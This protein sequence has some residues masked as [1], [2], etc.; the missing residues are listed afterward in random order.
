MISRSVVGKFY[1][2]HHITGNR[3][4]QSFEEDVRG[5]MFSAWIGNNKDVLDLGGRDGI[6][7]RHYMDSNR[8][9][10]ADAD[11]GALSY[12]REHYGVETIE[13]NLNE[14]LAIDEDSVDVV[15]MAEVLEHL[16]Y[17][18]FVLSEVQRV[19]KPGGIFVGSVPLAYHII[20]R[21]KVVRGK[22]LTI[23]G[24]PTHLQFFKYEEA[25]ELLSNFFDI[26]EIKILKGG[27]KGERFPNLFA[28]DIAFLCKNRE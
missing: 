8:V 2:Q 13:V 28:R 7:T 24:D 22:K 17:P 26:C 6:L 16:P 9:V 11:C 4:R 5:L 25:I 15:V 23:A 14:R 19:L 1:E 27:K 10:I 3:L 12:A 18:K 21:W 20:D